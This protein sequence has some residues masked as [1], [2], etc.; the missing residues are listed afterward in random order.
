MQFVSENCNVQP[1]P[2]DAHYITRLGFHLKKKQLFFGV[3]K[4][5]FS[6]HIKGQSN[7]S[8]IMNTINWAFVDSPTK[9]MIT[10]F[11]CVFDEWLFGNFFRLLGLK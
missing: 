11:D 3:V 4:R 1:L 9:L 8:D 5:Q 10:K 6:A 7:Y 2:T